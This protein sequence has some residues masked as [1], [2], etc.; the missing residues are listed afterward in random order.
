MV[1]EGI[2][3]VRHPL[4]V[5][6]RTALITA[7][8]HGDDTLVVLHEARC[9]VE[10][11]GT[12]PT[13]QRRITPIF[14]TGTLHEDDPHRLA[15]FRRDELIHRG[16][17]LDIGGGF[18]HLQAAKHVHLRVVAAFAFHGRGIPKALK[19]VHVLL[20]PFERAE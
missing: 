5:Y 18:F 14:G 9:L 1:L 15:G 12:D 20:E 7:R 10:A 8:E 2:R 13:L 16:A 17:N 11:V 19:H 4:P 6:P 3:L